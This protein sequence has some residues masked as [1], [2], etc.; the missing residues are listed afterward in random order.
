MGEF[1]VYNIAKHVYRSEIIKFPKDILQ[2]PK[3]FLNLLEVEESASETEELH[4]I[5]KSSWYL[6]IR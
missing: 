3:H 5:R 2:I 1:T 4:G 6:I